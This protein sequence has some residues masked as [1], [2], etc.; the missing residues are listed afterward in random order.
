MRT[1]SST[2]IPGTKN[3][4]GSDSEV[5]CATAVMFAR[6]AALAPPTPPPGLAQRIIRD[7][8]RLAQMPAPDS[9]MR[10]AC[11]RAAAPARVVASLQVRRAAGRRSIA[12]R[13]IAG[14]ASL[15][16]GLAAIALM[17][18]ATFPVR[19]ATHVAHAPPSRL[20]AR[21]QTRSNQHVPAPV[22]ATKVPAAHLAWTHAVPAP[23]PLRADSGETMPIAAEPAA[24]PAP[25]QIAVAAAGA[26][27]V[28]PSRPV[29]G[30]VDTEAASS[31]GSGAQGGIG[32]GPA[33]GY[34]FTSRDPGMGHSGGSGA[35][36]R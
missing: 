17:L 35:H 1:P 32:P 13:P 10:T 8:P 12:R 19:P 14:W 5:D 23:S 3:N 21:T 28:A 7:V 30:P 4:P 18:P 6:I 24:Q 34:A 11:L 33:P 29:Y 22:L 15:A 16:A 25:A 27:P 20:F 2:K 26:R 31:S 36:P 9:P